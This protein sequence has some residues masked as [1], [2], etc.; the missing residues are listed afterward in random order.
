MVVNDVTM[1]MEKRSFK[2]ACFWQK[3]LGFFLKKNSQFRVQSPS[4]KS[5]LPGYYLVANS[6]K[7]ENHFYQFSKYL[8]LA[9]LVCI[10]NPKPTLNKNDLE[11]THSF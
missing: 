7:A 2:H 5:V 3:Y 11:R 8:A 9:G 4:Y 10:T 1:E 6:K